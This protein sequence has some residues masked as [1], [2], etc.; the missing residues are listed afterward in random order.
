MLQVLHGSGL[1][2][3]E[4]PVELHHV[5]GQMMPVAAGWAQGHIPRAVT[6][7]ELPENSKKQKLEAGQ[8]QSSARVHDGLKSD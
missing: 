7:R 6:L 4:M 1:V 3:S 2:G 8:A 5:G